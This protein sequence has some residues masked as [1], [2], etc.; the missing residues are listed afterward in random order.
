M[1][2]LTHLFRQNVRH[3]GTNLPAVVEV[4]PSLDLLIA[5]VTTTHKHTFILNMNQLQTIRCTSLYQ[6]N[7]TSAHI[8]VRHKN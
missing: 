8:D 6:M 4:I 2:V 1:S 7:L 3:E 5:K